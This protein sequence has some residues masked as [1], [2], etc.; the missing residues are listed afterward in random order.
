MSKE[1]SFTETFELLNEARNIAI[2]SHINPDGDSIG[3]SLAM[4]QILK[5]MGKTVN[6][7]MRD[8]VPK[9]FLFLPFA[10]VIQK[11][12]NEKLKTD[13]LVIM[14]ARINRTGGVAE[15]FDAPILNIDH[16][17]SNDGLADFLI[18]D[19]KSSSCCEIVFE[20]MQTKNIFITPNIATCLY[21]GTASDTGFFKFDN[22]TEKTLNTAS[23]LVAAGANPFEVAE[24]TS[25]RNFEDILKIG[26]A[27]QNTQKFFDG[28]VAGIFLDEEF[29]DFAF[30]EDL[31][32][33]VR[34]I[35]G[36]DIAFIVQHK[37]KN[38]YRL[39]MRSHNADVRK[40]TSKLNGGGHTH[41]AGATLNG[42]F[43]DIKKFLLETIAAEFS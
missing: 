2:T 11:K 7:Y 17:L 26:K 10:E 9:N 35:E 39:R 19:A 22:T 4:Y 23:K 42:N 8:V 30:T 37:K 3:S 25:Q 31:I 13:L 6:I 1:I 33:S 20:F 16:H 5:N 12:P 24:K 36:V 43:S 21:T 28:N 40:I 34:F 15:M 41:A 32:N 29:S 27:L 38:T 18:L 14:D